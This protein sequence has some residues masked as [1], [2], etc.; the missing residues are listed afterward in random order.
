MHQGV[1]SI[2]SGFFR[3]VA[4]KI[5]PQTLFEMRTGT[6]VAAVRGTQWLSEVTPEATA[7][8]VLQGKVAVV[9]TH[10]S[11][12]GKVVLTPGQ[13]TDVRGNR[14]P[15]TA[16]KKWAEERVSRLLRATELP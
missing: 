12:R 13:G 6:A 14:P 1:V 8:V 9:H 15:P 5:L 2:A 10:R 4:R 7:I 3:A 11:I 16:L